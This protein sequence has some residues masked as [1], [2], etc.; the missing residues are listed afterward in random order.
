MIG[1]GLGIAAAIVSALVGIWTMVWLASTRNRGF[2]PGF[3]PLPGVLR[4][5]AYDGDTLSQLPLLMLPFY[6]SKKRREL[7]IVYKPKWRAADAARGGVPEQGLNGQGVVAPPSEL[8]PHL[9]AFLF[10]PQGWKTAQLAQ[11]VSLAQRGELQVHE[12]SSTHRRLRQLEASVLAGASEPASLFRTWNSGEPVYWDFEALKSRHHL[13]TELIGF[14]SKWRAGLRL[15][16]VGLILVGG[17]AVVKPVYLPVLIAALGIVAA[18]L[19]MSSIRRIFPKWHIERMRWL[20]FRSY[21]CESSNLKPRGD[22]GELFGRYL[23]YAIALG[24]T[25]EWAQHFAEAPMQKPTWWK[26]GWVEKSRKTYLPQRQEVSR[27]LVWALSEILSMPWNALARLGAF[28]PDSDSAVGQAPAIVIKQWRSS[29]LTA[30]ATPRAVDWNN[31]LRTVEY[32]EQLLR[33][34]V[35]DPD[36]HAEAFLELGQYCEGFL[37]RDDRAL[38]YYLLAYKV[39]PEAPTLARVLELALAVGNID[40]IID[41]EFRNRARSHLLE[42][43]G[44]AQRSPLAPDEIDALNAAE[45]IHKDWQA[46]A[47]QLL[48]QARAAQSIGSA[49]AA[50]LWFQAARIFYPKDRSDPR[51]EECLRAVVMLQPQHGLGNLLLENWLAEQRRFDELE[52]LQSGRLDRLEDEQQRLQLLKHFGNMWL[53]R[54]KD[55]TRACRFYAKALSIVY[56]GHGEVVKVFPGHV[57]AFCLL[58]EEL[59]PKGEGAAVLTLAELARNVRMSNDERGALMAQTAL[60]VSEDMRDAA[61]A[62]HFFA[63]ARRL[64]PDPD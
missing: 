59:G 38:S 34:E 28:T 58:R 54:W 25:S 16:L 48:D 41:T 43:K 6:R 50:R 15:G 45:S 61:R 4:P 10:N 2:L 21:L 11:L 8:P 51:Y 49:D 52:S 24:V 55:R 5:L 33:S 3:E 13:E 56:G 22:A 64:V 35:N 29:V 39:A 60:T 1:G 30:L 37:L 31:E 12:R 42:L 18:A 20:A 44:A 36:V 23:P 47:G 9:L 62:N 46:T 26:W 57:R 27:R 53:L 7:G 63:E 32:Y 17:L 19:A 14:P 40:A